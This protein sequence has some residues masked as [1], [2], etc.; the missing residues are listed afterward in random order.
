VKNFVKKTVL[1]QNGTAEKVCSKPCQHLA[2]KLEGMMIV[3]IL[4]TIAAF[5]IFLNNPLFKDP[6]FL[7]NTQRY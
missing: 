4:E 1:I 7:Y 2:R 3:F 5:L 6:L